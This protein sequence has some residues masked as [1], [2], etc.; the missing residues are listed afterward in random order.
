[1][2]RHPRRHIEWERARTVSS[3]GAAGLSA[4]RWNSL[5]KAGTWTVFQTYEWHE[6][7]LAAYGAPLRPFLVTVRESGATVGVAPLVIEQSTSGRVARFIG[8]GRS[9]YCDVI[10]GGRSE[11]TLA[12]ARALGECPDWDVLDLA[13]VRTQSPTT[14]ALAEYFRSRGY[15]VVV[16][17]QYVCPTLLFDTGDGRAREILNRASLRRRRAFFERRG[18]LDF[19]DLRKSG[20]ITPLLDPFFQ[21]HIARW[22]GSVPSL[23]LEEANRRFYLELTDRLCRHDWVLFS[24]VEL[25]GQPVAMH[26]GFDF[27]RRLVWYK[28][29][30]DPAFAQGSPGLVLVWHLVQAAESLGR[31]ELDFTIGDEPF[32][33]RFSNFV[34]TTKRIRVFRDS[35][36]YVLDQS[37]R[38]VVTA[39]KRAATRMRWS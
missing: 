16:E 1:M 11:V 20:Q 3:L 23:F 35:A 38:H 18:R 4:E 26:F 29:S 21:Q 25:D 2:S 27:D 9:D 14:S 12:L 5:A 6:S 13:N 17:D 10:T 28:P 34:R 19:R 22:G 15:G 33:R 36:R 24:S 7:W 8:D 32:K 37:R 30:F 31:V 39:L